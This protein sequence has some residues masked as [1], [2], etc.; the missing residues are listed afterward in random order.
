[1]RI[2]VPGWILEAPQLLPRGRVPADHR[3][4]FVILKE[5]DRFAPGNGEVRVAHTGRGLPELL[6]P[7]RRPGRRSAE[8]QE[9]TTGVVQ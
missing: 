3:F 1:M 2:N 6:R 7:G 5:S 8:E 4:I 9:I